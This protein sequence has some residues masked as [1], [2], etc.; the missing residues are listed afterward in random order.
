MAVFN[1]LPDR[2]DNSYRLR[3]R[4]I[5][6]ASDVPVPRF[7]VDPNWPKPLPQV[8]DA[9][10]Q[11]RRWVTGAV[12][13]VCVDSHDHVFTTNRGGPMSVYESFS[14]V[15]NNVIEIIHRA[16]GRIVGH[17]GEGPGRGAGELLTPHQVAVDSKGNVYVS[18]TVASNRV[19]RFVKQ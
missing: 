1:R 15:G 6:G 9:D 8:K 3:R 18:S 11:M 17:I 5:T 7:K 14:G 12:G 19:Q 10:G 13:G 16:S 4:R 2:G